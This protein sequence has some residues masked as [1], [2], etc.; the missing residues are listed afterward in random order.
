MAGCSS[1]APPKSKAGVGGAIGENFNPKLTGTIRGSVVWE[2]DPPAVP[3]IKLLLPV[4]SFE[5]EQPN[6]NAP[7]ID[8]KT[9]GVKDAL[10]FLKEV[11]LGE[12]K[13]WSHGDVEVAFENGKLIVR[14][15]KDAVRAGIVRRGSKVAFIARED[16]KHHLEA[17]G[18]V[19]F[20]L[21]LPKPDLVTAQPIQESG[22]VELS[23]A[24]GYYWLRGYL[25][26]GEHPYATTTDADGSFTLSQVP[27]GTFD[28]VAWMPNWH[29]KRH[30]RGPEFGEID[31]LVFEPAVETTRKLIVAAGDN[32]DVT[33]RLRTADFGPAK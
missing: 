33:L 20:S 11:D 26:A 21:P 18:A 1:Q 22:I 17:R 13:P 15:G 32:S 30:E 19:V 23:S 27:V 5:P 25:W 8:T 6:P 7:I 10:V 16:R 24:A 14:Q 28:V 29:V 3:P 12:S 4:A 9:R 2:S 31:R